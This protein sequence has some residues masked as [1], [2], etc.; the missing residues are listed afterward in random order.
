LDLSR[1]RKTG[2]KPFAFKRNLHRYVPGGERYTEIKAKLRE[3]KLSTVC[4]AGLLYKL[5]SSLPVA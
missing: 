5:I 2:C 3:L 4:E 1:E